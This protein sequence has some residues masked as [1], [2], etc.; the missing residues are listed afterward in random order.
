MRCEHHKDCPLFQKFTMSSVM[1]IW[2][3][4][5]CNSSYEN[6]ERFKMTERGEVVPPAMLP[7]GEVL[8]IP[9]ES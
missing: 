8:N 4:H 2:Q 5:Y 9:G 3:I 1:R 7:N 6:C